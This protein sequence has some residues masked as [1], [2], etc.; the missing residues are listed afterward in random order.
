MQR[1]RPR[2]PIARAIGVATDAGTSCAARGAGAVREGGRAC[3]RTSGTAQGREL[4]RTDGCRRRVRSPSIRRVVHHVRSGAGGADP[5]ASRRAEQPR[6]R[7]VCTRGG[8]AAWRYTCTKRWTAVKRGEHEHDPQHRHEDVERERDAEEHEPL[9]A[10]HEPAARVEAERF[11]A[12]PLVRDEHR[13][14]RDREREDRVVRRRGPTRYQATP[15]SSSASETRS[16]T[17]SKNAPRG[18]A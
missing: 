3:P 16:V 4:R 6:S 11:G 15:P 18:L 1:R 9:G 2:R 5:R 8:C 17:E 10:L 12:G 7:R 13:A 14:G